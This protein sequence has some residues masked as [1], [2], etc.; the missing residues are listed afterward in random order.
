VTCTAVR[1]L[2][3]VTTAWARGSP[4]LRRRRSTPSWSEDERGR[5]AVLGHP[6]MLRTQSGR[7]A[8]TPARHA[9]PPPSPKVCP[10]AGATPP[11]HP[12]SVTTRLRRRGVAPASAG[13]RATV[14]VGDDP[15]NATD[16]VPKQQSGGLVARRRPLLLFRSEH[17]RFRR[18][19][20]RP[21]LQQPDQGGHQIRAA[22][23]PRIGAKRPR[24]ALVAALQSTFDIC[25]ALP[26]GSRPSKGA[27]GTSG[28]RSLCHTAVG[29]RPKRKPR[30]VCSGWRNCS[31]PAASSAL[32]VY[33]ASDS[34]VRAHEM[35]GSATCF[36]PSLL[37]AGL[38]TLRRVP[39]RDVAARPRDRR[40]ARRSARR[41][42]LAA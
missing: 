40:L 41:R 8:K 12:I 36:H 16:C 23:R 4:A 1:R 39:R 3:S 31:D 27:H 32:L 29:I 42:D 7:P 20:P 25:D 21:G 22:D 33:G 15:F 18:L 5:P 9:T 14:G 6:P 37:G 34:G 11:W 17:P 28:R 13:G 19:Q 35:A 38:P 10:S 30:I 24:R 26:T 2:A